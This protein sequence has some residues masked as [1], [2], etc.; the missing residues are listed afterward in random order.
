VRKRHLL[1]GGNGFLGRNIVKRLLEDGHSVRVFDSSPLKSFDNTTSSYE[2]VQGNFDRNTNFIQLL[3]NVDIVTHLISTTTPASSNRDIDYDIRSNLQST[4]EL[5]KASH[6]V[7]VDKFVFASSG[8]TVY[9]PSEREYISEN[10]PTDPIC[11]YGIVKLAI[12]KYI[13]FFFKSAKTIGISLRISN[14]YGVGQTITNLQGLIGTVISK[15]NT[16]DTFELWGSGNIVRDYV[17]IDDVVDA[18]MQAYNY[19]GDK[20]V[21]NIGSGVGAS[22]NEIINL[23]E[24]IS[25]KSLSINFSQTRE[26]DV[27][28]N[29]L[30]NSLAKSELKWVPTH[31]LRAGILKT[32]QNI[33]GKY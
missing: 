2:Y 24:E 7:G 21:F 30:D 19:N 18:F 32:M 13:S 6:V 8:G 4:I 3:D 1:F 9:G 27:P 16:G 20:R 5:L 11:S 14:P 10:D 15:I 22:I 26:L 17:F 29:V 31:D 23:I 25:K 12:E 28:R 33:S